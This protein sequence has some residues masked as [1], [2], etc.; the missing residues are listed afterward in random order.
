MSAPAATP[1]AVPGPVRPR[2]PRLRRGLATAPV[3]GGMLVEGG[4][5]RQL[6]RGEAAIALLPRLLPGLDGTRDRAQI[7]AGL[8]LTLPQLDQALSLLDQC[9]LLEW[10]V[11]GRPAGFAADHVATYLSRTIGITD[12][13]PAADEYADR[14]AGATVLVAAPAALAG[15][16]A[17]D[18]SELGVG[19]VQRCCTG[20]PASP[21]TRVTGPVVAA[22]FDDPADE[23]SLAAAV[24]AWADLPVLRFSATADW[25]EVGPAF[26][27]SETACVPCFRRGQS[28]AAWP[29]DG[30]APADP[31]TTG[32]LAGLVTSALLGMLA[33]QPP[34]PPPGRLVRTAVPARVTEV[35]DVLPE[36]GCPVC[37]GGTPPP[38]PVAQDLLAYEWRMAKVHPAFEP[39]SAP[40]PAERDWLFAL[41]RQRDTFSSSP[42]HRLP[43]QT[44][45]PGSG[46]GLSEPLLAAI[47]ARTAGFRDA[48]DPDSRRW[49][50]SGGNMASVAVY[51]ATR[52]GLF[53]L[54]GTIYRYDDVGHE[55]LSVRADP[56]P[57][58]QIL[59]GTDLDRED[60]DIALVLV[61]SAGR[62]SQK[63]GDF[64]WRL[65]HLDSGCA[66]LQLS[67]VAA[68]CGLQTTFASSWPSTLSDQLELDPDREVITAV[69]G[70]R[71]AASADRKDSGSCR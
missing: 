27:R 56:V 65:T 26:C 12:D 51:L 60:L 50:P 6:L 45:P 37:C 3:P 68:S 14:L 15:L 44:D 1:A 28:P 64:A 10:V 63:Y 66:A 30:S 39:V 38:D 70:L 55:L 4:P 57:L 29:A 20:Q 48:T 24:A 42:R 67:V 49:A 47:L 9:G 58:M 21:P 53:G 23:S 2:W 7:A 34:P 33:Q 41:Q 22:V 31:A 16:I 17:A 52:A 5:S 11:P 71:S 25:V 43:D 18:L 61:G 59:A 19:L 40:I 35:W 36:P 46:G 69:A 32:L 54:P 13:C 62:L 8:S